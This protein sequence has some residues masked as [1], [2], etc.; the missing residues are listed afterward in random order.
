MAAEG[1]C[2]LGALFDDGGGT[3]WAVGGLRFR[4]FCW[5]VAP[6]FLCRLI[7]SLYKVS[8]MLQHKLDLGTLHVIALLRLQRIQPLKV[9]TLEKPPQRTVRNHAVLITE[10]VH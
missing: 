7:P 5:F 9:D 6:F 10:K 3:F 1:I 8:Y 2:G 4:F